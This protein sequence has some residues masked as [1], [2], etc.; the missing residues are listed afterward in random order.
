MHLSTVST[1][2][3]RKE[4]SLYSSGITQR[5][6]RLPLPTIFLVPSGFAVSD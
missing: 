6:I 5:H 1:Q 3:L 4:P 2:S